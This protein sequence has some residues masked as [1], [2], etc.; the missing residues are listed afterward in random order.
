MPRASEKER[1]AFQNGIC[2]NIA[3]NLVHIHINRGELAEKC[4]IPKSTLSYRMSNPGTFR[5]DELQAIANVFN[6]TFGQLCERV[7]YRG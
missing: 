7:V 5:I 3:A 2:E 4:G 6:I 1:L